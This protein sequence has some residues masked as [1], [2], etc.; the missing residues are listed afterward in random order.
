MLWRMGLV[1]PWH[2][3]SSRTGAQTHV[4]CIGWQILNHCTTREVPIQR[5]LNI[6]CLPGIILGVRDTPVSK[7]YSPEAMFWWERWTI[8]R[9]ICQFVISV[10]KARQQG[11]GVKSDGAG[12]F[13]LHF[14]R[15]LELICTSGLL[16]MLS[17]SGSSSSLCQRFLFAKLPLTILQSS[18][19]NR[20][21]KKAFSGPP[22]ET[23]VRFLLNYST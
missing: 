22:E 20:F 21:L 15:G 14:S 23:K 3:G 5:I 2:V 4:P 13:S 17:L 11:E 19:P 10:I 7:D 18:A 16:Q 1:A 9:C 12:A 6:Y 8:N